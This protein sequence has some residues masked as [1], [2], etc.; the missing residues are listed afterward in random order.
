MDTIAKKLIIH[1][2]ESLEM[3]VVQILNSIE[4][5]INEGKWIIS[6]LDATGGI[7]DLLT[8]QL[9]YLETLSL[10]FDQIK[11]LFDEDGQVIEFDG[12]FP[13]INPCIKIVIR[14]GMTVDILFPKHLLDNIILGSCDELN[15]ELYGWQ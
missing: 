4:S 7:G 14:D 5:N 8:Q 13:E 6:D 2:S 3:R 10:N 12:E 9:N 11:S 15:P 1:S